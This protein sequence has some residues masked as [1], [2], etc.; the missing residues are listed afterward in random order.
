MYKLLGVPGL[1]VTDQPEVGKVVGQQIGYH[2]RVGKHALTDYDWL[3]YL[4][5]ADRHLGH[6]KPKPAEQ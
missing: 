5:F 3:R 6:A 1:D 4:D 2:I